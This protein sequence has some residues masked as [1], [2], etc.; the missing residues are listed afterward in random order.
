MDSRNLKQETTTIVGDH[1]R[2]AEMG[3]SSDAL[4]SLISEKMES[5]SPS[6][7]IYVVPEILRKGNENSFE[8]VLVSIGPFHHDKQGLEAMEKHKWR[9]LR[10]LLTRKP[11]L[12]S[13]LDDCV[14]AMK[15]LEQRARKCYQEPTNMSSNEFVEMMI[16]DGCFT[17]ELFLT[18]SRKELRQRREPIFANSWMLFSVRII[19]PGDDDDILHE[20]F[21]REG[22]HLLD[23]VGNTY[24]PSYPKVL[25]KQNSEMYRNVN[26]AEKLMHS[27][28][29]F[30][31]ATDGISLL[32]IKFVNGV[33]KIPP[34]RIHNYTNNLLRNLV[35]LELCSMNSTMYVT[36]Y[37]F[38]MDGLIQS[39]NDVQV[40]RQHRIITNCLGNDEMVPEFF[41]KLV[42]DQNIVGKDNFYAGLC[43][44]VNAYNRRTTNKWFNLL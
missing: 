39:P 4:V 35:A 37:V 30:K 40:L 14:K 21:S 7:C 33:L 25:P 24:L 32:N 1:G 16:V 18:Y 28:I 9:Y 43:E 27:G 19:I 5:V 41:K 23:L 6:L 38:F 10:A 42:C 17:I 44:Q 13:V 22:N 31:R 36:S 11:N 29:K 34:L 3:N 15:Q 20:K 26:P 2:I 12:E 8:P